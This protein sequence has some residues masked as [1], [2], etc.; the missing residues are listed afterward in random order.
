[1]GVEEFPPGDFMTGPYGA[2]GWF[3][4]PVLYVTLKEVKEIFFLEADALLY[5]NPWKTGLLY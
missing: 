1:M 4:Y 3:R 5:K 2:V